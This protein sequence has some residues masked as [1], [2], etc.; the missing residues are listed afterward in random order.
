M[1]EPYVGEIRLLPYGR[2]PQG[3][4]PCDGSLQPI[5]PYQLLFTL[6][7]T[8]YGGD[9]ASTFGL[10]DLRGRVPMHQGTGHGL[11]PRTLG[12]MAG[13]ETVTLQTSQAGHVHNLIASQDAATDTKPSAD[14]TIGTVATGDTL[15]CS[16][17]G[18]S[19]SA[20]LGAS[21]LSSVGTALPHENCAPTLPVA[22]FICFE[23]LF[24]SQ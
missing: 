22:A 1:T 16:G 18:T 12:Q 2:T 11:S 21:S 19:Q 6:I 3:W 15:Y 17:A 4:L 23:G 7:S 9:G 24:P 8:T 14:L 5:D 20:T 13:S 10:P